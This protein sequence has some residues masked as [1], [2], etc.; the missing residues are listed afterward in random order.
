MRVLA[1]ITDP[2]VLDAILTR[3]DLPTAPL[4]VATAC[5]P[6]QL[7]MWPDAVDPCPDLDVFDPA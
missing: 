1:A 5:A 7:A 4:P 2:D 6:P 3:L